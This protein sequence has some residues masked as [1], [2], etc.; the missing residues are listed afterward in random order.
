MTEDSV[1]QSAVFEAL[2][3][4]EPQAWQLSLLNMLR[5]GQIPSELD[6]PR[7][8]QAKASFLPIWLMARVAGGQIPRR[9]A[10]CSADPCICEYVLHIAHEIASK[11]EHDADLRKRLGLGHERL[12]VSR[13]S[14]DD[15]NHPAGLKYPAAP[16]AAP[17]IAV[18][19]VDAIVSRVG[20]GGYDTGSGALRA[21]ALFVTYEAQLARFLE[22]LP[23]AVDETG[24]LSPRA[25]LRVLSL[26]RASRGRSRGRPLGA[27]SYEH[28]DK[29][30]LEEM[31]QLIDEGRAV[32]A[33]HAA[34]LVAD[35][36]FRRGT[37]KSTID[38]LAKRFRRMHPHYFARFKSD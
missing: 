13:L 16:V 22:A 31:K 20:F 11:L 2:T 5:Q 4:R 23:H 8:I 32:S 14:S 36:A 37:V 10:F 30:K 29:P 1:G 24:T 18:G 17:V 9:L 27:G 19:G 33:E 21:D 15:R 12:V 34:K 25:P 35:G 6:L 28:L 7:G 3:G 26:L 38:R